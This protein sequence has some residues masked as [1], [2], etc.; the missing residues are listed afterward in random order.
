MSELEQTPQTTP[1]DD[2]AAHAVDPQTLQQPAQSNAPTSVA[3][4]RKRSQDRKQGTLITL[5]SGITLRIGRPSVNNL[6][7]T[8]QLP[9]ELANAAIKV[10]SGTPNLTDHDM[11]KYVEY[12]ERIVLLSV[13]EPKI[14]ASDPTDEQIALEDLGDDDR[15]EILL[16]VNGGLEA[17]AKFRADGSGVSA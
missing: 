3:D 14:V 11:K 15:N 2:A 12:N 17:L 16:Y 6:V 1:T 5:S 9:A 4:I 10:Q 8:G 13:M 7:K